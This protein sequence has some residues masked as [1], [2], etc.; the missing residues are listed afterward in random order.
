MGVTGDPTKKYEGYSCSRP[1]LYHRRDIRKRGGGEDVN[2][3]I[4]RGSSEMS[5][6]DNRRGYIKACFIIVNAEWASTNDI[7]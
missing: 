7:R 6:V 5:H 4:F 1:V 2:R 3:I